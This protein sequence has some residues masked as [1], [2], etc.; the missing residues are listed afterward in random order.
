[1]PFA[2]FVRACR[3]DT[4]GQ[5][6]YSYDVEKDYWAWERA[7]TLKQHYEKLGARWT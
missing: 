2:E 1:M 5:D 3:S 6:I 7:T 4:L